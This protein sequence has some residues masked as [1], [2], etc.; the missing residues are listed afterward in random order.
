M[1]MKKLP[2]KF[3]YKQRYCI[4]KA[5]SFMKNR[6]AHR[7]LS[8]GTS[9]EIL[10]DP[11]SNNITTTNS[12]F[13]CMQHKG[14]FSRSII[15]FHDIII[16][17]IDNNFPNFRHNGRKCEEQKE[18]GRRTEKRGR[19]KRQGWSGGEENERQMANNVVREI[20]V[21]DGYLVCLDL[22]L[23]GVDRPGNGA[24]N[25]SCY[26]LST[27]LVFPWRGKGDAAK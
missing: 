22:T 18:R 11:F 5:T 21:C 6:T 23:L 24:R 3:N 16:V 26:L 17:H 2:F 20:S 4:L 15:I 13:F 12:E 7:R 9:K 8:T 10:N 25:P 19:I 14:F 27:A 1:H